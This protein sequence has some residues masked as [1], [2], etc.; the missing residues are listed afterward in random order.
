[1]P[2]DVAQHLVLARRQAQQEG[3]EGGRCLEEGQYERDVGQLAQ[4][5]SD[6]RR[7]VAAERLSG[8]AALFGG[9]GVD[10]TA[11]GDGEHPGQQ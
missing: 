10:A 9:G 2:G 1:M 11:P 8:L 6:H 7:G 3:R 5:G 4:M